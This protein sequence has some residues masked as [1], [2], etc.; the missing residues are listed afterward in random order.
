MKL[1]DTI[2]EG[3]YH[4]NWVEAQ[5]AMLYGV[6]L[7]SMSRDDLLVCVTL[8]ERF[9]QAQIQMWNESKS[10]LLGTPE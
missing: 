7:H 5:D 2:G 9:R 3:T 1:K 8:L 6:P 4:K 10:F